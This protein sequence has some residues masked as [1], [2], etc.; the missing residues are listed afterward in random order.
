MLQYSGLRG[1]LLGGPGVRQKNFA[2]LR[3][4]FVRRDSLHSRAV[5]LPGAEHDS[6]H[7]NLPVR[8]GFQSDSGLGRLAL[9]ARGDP[10]R[11]IRALCD[12]AVCFHAAADDDLRVRT[13]VALGHLWNVL[14][15]FW[16]QFD[17]RALLPGVFKRE[18]WA[19]RQGIEELICAKTG[20]ENC[21]RRSIQADTKDKLIEYYI[22]SFDYILTN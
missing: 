15:F 13:V 16:H 4:T 14:D 3:L 5:P 21:M 7:L 6:L 10:G 8:D 2:R 17:R 20:C 12:D 9:R 1:L 22:R 11:T 18:P 19:H